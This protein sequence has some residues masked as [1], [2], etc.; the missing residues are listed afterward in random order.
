MTVDCMDLAFLA[1]REQ[2]ALQCGGMPGRRPWRRIVGVLKAEAPNRGSLRL[3][4]LYWIQLQCS[5]GPD[6][7]NR[8]GVVAETTATVLTTMVVF[9]DGNLAVW[10]LHI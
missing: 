10:T 5:S 9:T 7:Q 2:G 3:G 6:S 8:P 4:R 1:N